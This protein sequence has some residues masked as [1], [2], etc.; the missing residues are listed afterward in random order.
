MPNEIGTPTPQPMLIPMDKIHDMPGIFTPR[1]P[2]R[3]LG[4]LVTSIQSG[5]VKEPV[6]V[7][8]REDGHYQLLSGY[9]RRKANELANNKEIPAFVY[10]M[11][12]QEA[13]AYRK[14]VRDNPDAPIPGKL[15]NPF[16]EQEKGKE[17]D[18]PAVSEEK[19]SGQMKIGAVEDEKKPD[20]PEKE[21]QA[22]EGQTPTAPAAEEKDQKKPAE[23]IQPDTP[24]KDGEAPTP[25][26]ESKEQTE[27]ADKDK[28]ETA[29]APAAEEKAQD[30]DDHQPTV[31]EITAKAEA[32]EVVNISD[33]IDAQQ[34]EREAKKDAPAPERG[35]GKN[36][37]K[38]KATLRPSSAEAQ[39]MA[40]KTAE[41]TAEA[42]AMDA[43]IK[44]G[45]S[46][47]ITQVLEDRL[48]APDEDALKSLP[49]PGDGESFFVTLHPAYLEKSPLNTFSVDT[50]SENFKEL[51]KSIELV[52]IK[53]PVLAR[54]N[55]QGKL[56]ILS[57]QRR[58]LA[59]TTLNRAVPTII[60]KIDDADAKI[61]VADGNLH[62]D[63][64]SSYDLSRAL[65]MK[66]EGMK[67]KAGRRKRGYSS[68][69]L[70]SDEKLAIEM[71]M[72]TA[73]L[74]RIVRLSEAVKGVCDLVDDNKLTISVAAEISYLKPKNQEAL[75]HL[76]QLD[77]KPTNVQIQRMKKAEAGGNLD[78]M[79]MRNILTDKDIAP[80]KQE[81]PKPAESA[82]APQPE[83]A[84]TTQGTPDAPTN[85]P[86][87][88]PPSPDVAAPVNA[89]E[90]P[91]ATQTPEATPA[92]PTAGAAE[93]PEAVK[94][95]NPFKGEQERPEVTK[96]IL[97]GDRLRKYFPDVTMTPR[98]IEDSVY[99]AL[100]ERRQRQE[101]SKQKEAIFKRNGPTR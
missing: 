34:R 13:I 90:A 53:D 100:E 72:S 98:E 95:E 63:K 43:A 56:E 85:A 33:L 21:E 69:E 44:G 30:K 12:T 57:G 91:A 31:A 27:T 80:K 70:Q 10:E 3:T 16:P 67:Q 11:S 47:A 66:M 62:R 15:L 23:A 92:A 74:N 52:G 50:E 88:I 2:E 71:G 35:K 20:G 49:V 41:R 8:Q 55:A 38:Q 78:E 54:F 96:V 99:D 29:Q 45:A 28:T 7:R 25:A 42:P 39:R 86:T 79:T 18:A 61:L 51:C 82:P 68:T 65:R 84:A 26:D 32:G 81:A 36:K 73:K 94:E 6:I 60:Q 89:A 5:G 93:A 75:L 4:G 14:A 46:T 22:K 24:E 64:I 48:K 9:R 101:R 77:Y 58:H 40:K 59:A 1:P 97:T 37:D 76:M 83:T 87:T 17:A 19:E